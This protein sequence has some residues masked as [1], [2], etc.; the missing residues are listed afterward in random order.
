MLDLPVPSSHILKI[1]ILRNKLPKQHKNEI[2][3]VERPLKTILAILLLLL[4]A[5]DRI[6]KIKLGLLPSLPQLNKR[7][8]Q[9]IQLHKGRQQINKNTSCL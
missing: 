3:N 9:N 1:P 7:P 6:N 4:K 8:K 5:N 2:P